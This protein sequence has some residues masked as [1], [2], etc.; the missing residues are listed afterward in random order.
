M[1]SAIDLIR[2]DIPKQESL[3]AEEATLIQKMEV[4]L[5]QFFHW[6][7]D[8]NVISWA[9][10]KIDKVRFIKKTGSGDLIFVLEGKKIKPNFRVLSK[11]AYDTLNQ[12]KSESARSEL[13]QKITAIWA[14]ISFT[15]VEADPSN[16]PQLKSAALLIKLTLQK[17][18]KGRLGNIIGDDLNSVLIIRESYFRYV[19]AVSLLEDFKT[20]AWLNVLEK[21]PMA[22]DWNFNYLD[23]IVSFYPVLGQIPT[24]ELLQHEKLAEDGLKEGIT[25]FLG[26]EERRI[27]FST[28][29]HSIVRDIF[30]HGLSPIRESDI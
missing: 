20:T 24:K 8:E 16:I 15:H 2:K 22:M 18:P 14:K 29:C 11:K 7:G 5:L 26:E 3:S 9:S 4:V 19:S 1:L 25:L 27:T 12:E 21:W 6:R 17:Y 23:A 13:F 28:L 30:P 10:R